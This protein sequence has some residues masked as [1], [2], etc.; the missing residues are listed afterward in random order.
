MMNFENEY[1][2]SLNDRNGRDA[3][4]SILTTI[5]EENE[6]QLALAPYYYFSEMEYSFLKFTV[7]FSSGSLRFI[8]LR[9]VS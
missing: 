2:I 5:R 7:A 1:S 4:S 8:T 9:K 6:A 3:A